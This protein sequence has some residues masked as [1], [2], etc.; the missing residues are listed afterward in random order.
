MLQLT[1]ASSHYET[2]VD[3]KRLQILTCRRISKNPVTQEF[4]YYSIKV[5]K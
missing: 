3:E 1:F 5:N 2:T 4:P